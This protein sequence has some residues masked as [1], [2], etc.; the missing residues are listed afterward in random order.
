MAA[1]PTILVIDDASFWRE[2]AEQILKKGGY[3]TLVA[4]SGAAALEL[5]RKSTVSLILLDSDM[6]Q[7]SG[8]QFLEIL[9]ADD[10]WKQVPVLMLTADMRRENIIQAHKLGAAEYLLKAKFSPQTVL[11]RV[12]KHM[13]IA[14]EYLITP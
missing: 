8:L 6:P 4:D 9:R 13:S 3:Q 1:I 11:S 5:L 10:R 14:P 12:E 2:V 7:M